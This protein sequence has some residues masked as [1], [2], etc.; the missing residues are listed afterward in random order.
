MTLTPAT[1]TDG[2]HAPKEAIVQANGSGTLIDK[3]IRDLYPALTNEE[4]KQARENLQRYFEVTDDF[5]QESESRSTGGL[6]TPNSRP[7]MKERS[8]VENN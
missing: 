8:K 7:T 1:I 3:I 4:L 2:E 6:D 5:E